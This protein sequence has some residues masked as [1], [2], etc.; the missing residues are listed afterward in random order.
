MREGIA[1]ARGIIG[2]FG[3]YED[4]VIQVRGSWKDYVDIHALSAHG[5]DLAMALAAA[6]AIDK[7]FDPGAFSHRRMSLNDWSNGECGVAPF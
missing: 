7:S 6:K 2:R 1:C 4:A 3:G 5:I